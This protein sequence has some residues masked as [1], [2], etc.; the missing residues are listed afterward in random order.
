M[1][2]LHGSF[3]Y[4]SIVGIAVVMTDDDAKQ[5][6]EPIRTTREYL[7]QPQPSYKPTIEIHF[8]YFK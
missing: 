1:A 3:M 8:F 2:E 4:N 7:V 6:H 5:T